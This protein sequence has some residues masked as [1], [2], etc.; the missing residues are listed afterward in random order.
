MPPDGPRP[1]PRAAVAGWWTLLGA[2]LALLVLRA[3]YETGTGPATAFDASAFTRTLTGRPG[4][5]LLARLALLPIAAVFAPRLRKRR[6][7]RPRP[8]LAGGAVFA[9]ALA[10]TWAAAEHASAGIQVPVAMA[11]TVLHLLAM[12][13]WLGGLMA[14]L[15]LLHRSEVPA[16]AVAR[17]SRLAFVSVTVLAVT[18]VYQ[19]WRG[20]GSWDALTGI[21]YGRLLIAKLAAVVLLLVAAGLSRRWTARLVASEAETVV[22][23]RVPERVGGPRRPRRRSRPSPRPRVRAAGACAGPSWPRSPSASWCW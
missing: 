4:L 6:A 21:T 13:V 8:L 16:A 5:A 20:L 10:L 18:G 19:S 23:E 7:R 11:S 12:A 14:L 9:V 2:T 3:P 22:R 1:A 15:T 17:F